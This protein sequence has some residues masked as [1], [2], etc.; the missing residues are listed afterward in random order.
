MS[1]PWSYTPAS[2]HS[3]PLHKDVPP[4]ESRTRPARPNTSGDGSSAPGALVHEDTAYPLD[5]P[6][7]IGRAPTGDESVRNAVATPL[8]VPRDRHVSRIHAFVTVERGKVYVRDA[9]TPAGTYIAAPGAD[10]WT[11]IGT[12]TTELAPGW[13]IRIGEKVLITYRG[14]APPS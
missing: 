6:Y 11:R 10:S 2:A 7:V 8:E 9:G 1:Q 5:R 4:D 13:S 3:I 12:A 14:T